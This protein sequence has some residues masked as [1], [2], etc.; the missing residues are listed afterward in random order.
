MNGDRNKN[1][2]KLNPETAAVDKIQRCTKL[3]VSIK[4]TL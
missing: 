4:K 1:L 2:K 3:L